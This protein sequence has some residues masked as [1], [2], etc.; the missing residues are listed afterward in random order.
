MTLH[1]VIV[2]RFGAND[3]FLSRIDA[4]RAELG[5]GVWHITNAALSKPGVRTRRVGAIELETELT[6]AKILESFAAPET[7]SFWSLP[8]FIA[9]LENAG[10]SAQRHK[11]QW[12][13]LLATPLLLAAMILLAAVFSLRPQRQGHVALVIVLGLLTGFLLYFLTNFVFALGLSGK[14]PVILAGWAPAGVSGMLGLAMLLHLED[15]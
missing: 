7:I 2:F 13:H 1:R 15:G 11:L 9:L 10:F 8:G 3:R 14:I 5:N 4:S 12:N 6:P